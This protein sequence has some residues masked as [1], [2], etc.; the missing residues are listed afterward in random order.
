[1]PTAHDRVAAH[2]HVVS[3][4]LD[5]MGE[6]EEGGN[7]G[8][9]GQVMARQGCGLVVDLIQSQKLAGRALLLV[10]PPGTG[11]TAL[12]IAMSKVVGKNVPFCPMVASQVYSKEVQKTEIMTEHFRKAIGL[13][14]RENKEVYEGEV[15]ELTVEETE[16]PVQ[17]GSYGRSISHV[18]LGLKTTKGSKTLKLDPTMYDSLSKENVVVGD[19]IYIETNSGAVKR[20]GRSDSFASEFDL[21]A[22]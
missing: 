22:E 9:V 2:T 16:D 19:V 8:L 18:I 17:S 10:G 1:M 6:V 21:E 13:R 20:V 3:L 14:I 11:K 15:T 5:E 12:A 4:G 7:C